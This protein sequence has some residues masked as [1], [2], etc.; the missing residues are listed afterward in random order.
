MLRK[1][2]QLFRQ[3]SRKGFLHGSLDIL[4]GKP[5]MTCSQASLPAHKL[6][7]TLSRAYPEAW[8]SVWS[9]GFLRVPQDAIEGLAK[10]RSAFC[11]QSFP[12][13]ALWGSFLHAWP[14][15]SWGFAMRCCLEA[16]W[17]SYGVM[18]PGRGIWCGIHACMALL[19]LGL[20]PLLCVCS[21][22]VRSVATSLVWEGLGR[23]LGQEAQAL[24]WPKPFPNIKSF[25]FLTP[26]SF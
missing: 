21:W 10:S 11:M 19:R 25:F 5:C 24:T 4:A 3:G 26:F 14:Q 17:P 18:W 23:S 7:R 1:K 12:G 9:Q 2:H 22:L 16:C 13:Y 8:S 15:G 20:S 6:S